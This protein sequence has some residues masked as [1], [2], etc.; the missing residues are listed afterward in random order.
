VV[1]VVVLEAVVVSV[2]WV[3]L[4][5]LELVRKGQAV[6]SGL[7]VGQGLEEEEE[8]EEGRQRPRTLEPL[9]WCREEVGLVVVGAGAGAGV[10]VLQALAVLS[11]LNG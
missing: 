6:R 4:H 1:V 3:G 11:F 2:A 9:P 7:E 8:E 5:E 10:V